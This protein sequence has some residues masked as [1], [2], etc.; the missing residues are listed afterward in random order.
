MLGNHISGLPVID[1]AEQLVEILTEGD[2]LRRT[3]TGT[4]R[5]RPR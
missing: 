5:H 3:E 1:E 2:L 4:E